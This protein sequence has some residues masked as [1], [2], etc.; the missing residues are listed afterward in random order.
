MIDRVKARMAS[1]ALKPLNLHGILV[2]VKS[3]IEAMPMYLVSV[4]VVPK[5]VLKEIISL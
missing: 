1:W 4:L 2:M 3:V 5:L